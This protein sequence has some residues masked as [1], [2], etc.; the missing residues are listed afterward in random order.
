M[1]VEIIKPTP[2]SIESSI[3][4]F[5]ILKSLRF[6]IQINSSSLPDQNDI[7]YT[8]AC[9]AFF[10]LCCVR[11]L[12]VSLVKVVI[13]SLTTFH[14]GFICVDVFYVILSLKKHEWYVNLRSHWLLKN[15]VA[16]FFALSVN[17]IFSFINSFEIKKIWNSYFTEQ[18]LATKMLDVLSN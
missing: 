12:S 4:K 8:S 5:F 10:G 3:P 2:K 16:L 13:F 6:L 1:N 15:N 14:D 9:V 17:H 7:F 18:K 11:W